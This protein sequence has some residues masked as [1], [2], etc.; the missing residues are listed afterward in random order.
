MCTNSFIRRSRARKAHIH[1]VVVAN[2]RQSATAQTVDKKAI[3][4]IFVI[5]VQ[6]C[7]PLHNF[8]TA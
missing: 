7:D 5:S 2:N 4:W 6:K 3:Y 1:N 8:S